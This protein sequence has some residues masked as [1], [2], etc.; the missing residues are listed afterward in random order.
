MF[1]V[2][3]NDDLGHR[4][5][6]VFNIESKYKP[7]TRSYFDMIKNA[8]S[9]DRI[10]RISFGLGVLST[11]FVGPETAWGYLGIIPVFTG[12]VGWCPLYT[13]LGINTCGS[14]SNREN[15]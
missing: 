3:L 14:S 6:F 11:A 15:A 2:P 5:H 8:G 10:L 13:V 7:L 12:L 1:G 4:S 9:M